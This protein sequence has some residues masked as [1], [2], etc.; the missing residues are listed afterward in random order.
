MPPSYLRKHLDMKAA[1]TS[2][3]KRANDDPARLVR[4]A[5]WWRRCMGMKQPH[6]LEDAAL[7]LGLTFRKAKSLLRGE[8]A[9]VTAYHTLKARWCADMDVQVEALR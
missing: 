6:A 3:T 5:V 2:W 9:V 7:A 8:P 1:S 4:D